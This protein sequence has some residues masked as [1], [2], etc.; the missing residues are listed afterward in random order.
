MGRRS[1]K[2]QQQGLEM[3]LHSWQKRIAALVLGA[4]AITAGYVE[5]VPGQL[6]PDS[7][8]VIIEDETGEVITLAKAVEIALARNPLTRVMAARRQVA[9][10]QLASARAMRKP[11]LQASESVTTS[12]NP[13]FVFG[14]LLEQGRF[15]SNNFLI[16]SLNNPSALT[17]FRGGLFVR[18]P[19]FDQRQSKG[20]SDIAT[21]GQQ[22][23]DQ[24]AELAAQQIRFEV[25]KSFYGLLLAHSKIVVAD[26]AIRIA[27]ADLKTMRDKLET[28]FVVRSDLLAGEVQLAEFRQQMV[29]AT[30]EHA[31]AQA[32]LNTALGVPVDA[33]HTVLDQLSERSFPVETPGELRRL[34][35]Q[36]RPE[37]AGAMLRVRA[38]AR[39]LQKVRDESLPR[40]D[41]FS[42]L[43]LSGRS[44]ITGS[45]DFT[46]GASL[47]I[48]LFD[49]GRKARIDEAR[50][51][52]ALARAEQE[53]LAQQIAFEVTR[54]YQQFI[55]ARERLVVV[56]KIT[57]Q[58]SEA[59]RIVRDRYE[60]GLTTITEV[61]RAESALVRARSDVVVARHDY[62][63]A[64]GNVLLVTG[65]LKDVE[66]FGP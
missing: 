23:A 37:Y 7:S 19:L 18:L 43:G 24:Q 58:A 31:T 40:V 55:S 5:S 65:R 52:E 17:N 54:A 29:Q 66:S 30:G 27:E 25:I 56:A 62:Y 28:G 32:A 64:Y 48:N 45:S 4:A 1:Q 12:N 46:V 11:L 33:V 21:L 3:R 14:S 63:V 13:V 34:A 15:G 60:V 44:P 51:A 6:P 35:L 8:E 50:A 61:L 20:S 38:N 47:N 10:A 59:F 9:D 26:E 49:A 36:N 53:Q 39:Q 2:A 41:A 16:S 57:S 22:E 42:S